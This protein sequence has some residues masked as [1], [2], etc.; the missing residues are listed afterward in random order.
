MSEEKLLFSTIACPNCHGRST[1]L[2][3][4]HACIIVWVCPNCSVEL[5]PKTGDCCVFCSYGNRR[6]PPFQQEHA[7]NRH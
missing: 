7:Q 4:T 5:K 1:V 3:P 6:C 2:M